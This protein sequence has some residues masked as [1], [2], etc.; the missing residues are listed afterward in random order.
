MLTKKLIL[1]AVSL[2]LLVT[3]CTKVSTIKHP[4]QSQIEIIKESI[5]EIEAKEQPEYLVKCEWGPPLLK[6]TISAQD[7]AALKHYEKAMECFLRHNAWVDD[8]NK[9][10]D[11]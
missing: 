10:H 3:G 4:A 5:R 2:P 7:E 6:D 8:Y 11:K 9:R 1:L